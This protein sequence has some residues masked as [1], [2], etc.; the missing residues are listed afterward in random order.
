MSKVCMLT[1]VDNPFNPFKDFD[2][3]LMFDNE[4]GYNSKKRK[5]LRFIEQ[6]TRLSNSISLTLIRKYQNSNGDLVR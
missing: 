4:K 1:T 6:S 3:W 5:I 2:S